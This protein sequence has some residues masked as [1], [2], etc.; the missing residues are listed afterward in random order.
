MNWIKRKISDFFYVEGGVLKFKNFASYG[1]AGFG[2]NLIYGIMNS[3]LMIFYT[4]VFLVPS[5]VVGTMFLVSKLWDAIND[6][7]MGTLVDKTRT[8]W[9]KMRPYLLYTPV[10]IAIVNILIF[11]APSF[12]YTGKI[13]YMYITYIAWG[14]IYT[15]CDVPYWSLSSAMSPHTQER[16]NLVMV[17]R[18][19]TGAG[20]GIPSILVSALMALKGNEAFSAVAGS[21]QRI[22]FVSAVILSIVGASLLSLGFF[23]TKERVKQSEKAPSF[24]ECIKHLVF[25]KPLMMILLCNLLAFPKSIQWVASTYVATY[26]LGGGQWVVLLGIPIT[27]GNTV[28]YILTPMMT[29]RFGAIKT[30][31]IANVYSIVT[32]AI[33]FFVGYHHIVPMMIMIFITSLAGGMTGV[34]PTILIAD[35]VDYMEYKTGQRSEGVSFSVQTF[36]AK[37]SAA[38]QGW[39]GGLLLS[40][41]RYAQPVNVGAALVEQTQSAFTMSGMWAMYSII[42]AVGSIL[43][44]IPLLFY[45]LKGDKLD[46]VRAELAARR[47]AAE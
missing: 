35:C 46:K 6:P 21:N 28:S 25:N 5:T 44:V 16:T 26:L 40:A 37:A 10:P 8:K 43:C 11:S 36:M 7:F 19:L 9:G 31:L 38:L 3:Y 27:L 1:L 24:S 18:L 20:M 45:D 33:L 32:L 4:D 23:G 41:F 30:Y 2:Q 15:I 47:A 34:I 12:S 17:T 14:M 13:I 39:V 42:P 22:Y 29:K